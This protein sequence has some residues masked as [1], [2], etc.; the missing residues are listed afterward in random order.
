MDGVKVT[1]TFNANAFFQTLAAILSRKYG[2]EITVTVT[3]PAQDERAARPAKDR[4]KSNQ[5]VSA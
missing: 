2:K 3:P 5:R 4:S 1:G